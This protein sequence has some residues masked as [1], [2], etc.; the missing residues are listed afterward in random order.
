MATKEVDS[1]FTW[2]A[3]E[4]IGQEIWEILQ[5]SNTFA[6]FML[7]PKILHYMHNNILSCDVESFLKI[8]LHAACPNICF[9]HIFIL[10]FHPLI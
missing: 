1:A 6:L 8:I 10:L 5:K 7:D 3:Y 2:L 9:M 4:S